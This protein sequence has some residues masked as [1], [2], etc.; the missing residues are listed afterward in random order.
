MAIAGQVSR[1]RL[2]RYSHIRVE[3][4]R[5]ALEALTSSQ[6]PPMTPLLSPDQTAL[7]SQVEEGYGTQ[8]GTKKEAS[9]ASSDV[10]P[11]KK[12]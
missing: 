4:K 11:W 2:E 7:S 6:I 9:A 8:D 1:R 12:W 10:S 5:A 3:A